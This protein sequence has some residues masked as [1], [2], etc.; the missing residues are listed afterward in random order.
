MLRRRSKWQSQAQA[1]RLKE[2]RWRSFPL[3]SQGTGLPS[4]T[5]SSGSKRTRWRTQTIFPPEELATDAISELAE[6][7]AELNQV[8]P[9]LEGNA[10]RFEAQ[11]GGS[12]MSD[13]LPEGGSDQAECDAGAWGLFDGPFWVDLKTSDYTDSGV[14]VIRLGISRTCGS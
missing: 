9:L 14:R 7:V 6:A 1:Q 12:G 11:A 2:D 8:L 10:E 5:A 3:G 13:E 4:S